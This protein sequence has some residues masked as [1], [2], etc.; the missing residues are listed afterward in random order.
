[1]S[2]RRSIVLHLCSAEETAAIACR[3]APLL[4]SGDALLLQGQIGAGK[5]HFARALIQARLEAAKKVED[6]PSPTYTIVQIYDDDQAEIWHADLYRLMDS[7]EI[8]ELGLADAFEDAIC[9]VE[10]PDRL[11]AET[12]DGALW[13]SFTQGASENERHLTISTDS[14]RWETVFREMRVGDGVE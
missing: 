6:V 5:T 9:L 1:M 4:Q 3:I 14:A 2:S 8:S 7:T 13:L 11:G 10:W 12:P